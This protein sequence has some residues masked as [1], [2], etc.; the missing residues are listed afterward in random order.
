MPGFP[1]S[2][3]QP[4]RP[5]KLVVGA[6]WRA[7]Y[8]NYNK[9]LYAASLAGSTSIGP[10]IL[11][12]TTGPFDT[13]NMPAGLVDLGWI[14]DLKTT[15]ESKIGQVRSGYRGAVRAQYRGQAGDSFELKFREYGRKQ[16]QLA[17]GTNTINL[18]AA[19]GMS[20]GTTGPLSASGAP[21]A[22]VTAYAVTN[23]VPTLTLASVPQMSQIYQGS[24]IV[25]DQDYVVGQY[26][27]QGDSGTPVFK[28]SVT[29]VDY[30]RK[31]SDYTARVVSIAGNVVTLDQPF[32]G[33]GN[34]SPT[35]NYN[36][37]TQT[38][39]SFVNP[40][41]RC[42]AIGGF[43]SREGGTYLS[44]WT[45]LLVCNTIDQG[46]LV[47]Y[48]PH[49]SIQQLRDH[50]APWTID[51]IGTTDEGGMELDAQFTALAYDDPLDGETVTSYK[52]FYPQPGVPFAY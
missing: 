24:Y 4:F 10:Y 39:A 28:G 41:V 30:I 21:A 8:A 18:L 1:K 5:P 7:W 42:Q 19:S 46:Q 26:G 16:Y 20:G 27:L 12:M 34:G 6:G 40:Q 45:C 52:G 43:A 35:P 23:G 49:V 32:I 2:L 9:T 33:G 11:D 47:I 22:N 15:P 14:K 36:P 17:T 50:A 13:N 37:V 29:D 44:E 51:N 25:A 31:N 3:A 48:Y 38:F